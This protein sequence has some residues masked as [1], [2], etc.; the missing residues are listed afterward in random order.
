[1]GKWV[2]NEG[3]SVMFLNSSAKLHKIAKSLRNDGREWGWSKMYAALDIYV[4]Y[5]KAK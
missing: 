4:I 1:M 2:K 3:W 5:Y